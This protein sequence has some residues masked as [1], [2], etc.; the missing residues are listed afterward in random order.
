MQTG[1]DIETPSP[2]SQD[3]E[4]TSQDDALTRTQS[5]DKQVSLFQECLIVA[6]I[7]LAMFITQNALGQTVALV[8]IIAEHYNIQNP[9]VMSWF[10]AGY[11]LTV[12]TFILFSGRVGDL[13][14]W[15]RMLVIGY[16]WFGI[17]SI[18]SGLAWY[19]NHILFIFSRVMAG[20]GPAIALPNGLAMLGALYKPGKKKNMAFAIFGG[21]APG[22]AVSGFL[23]AGLF[24]LVW[25]PWAFWFI[26]L[27]LFATAA[28]AH[29][30]IP[31]PQDHKPGIQG[32]GISAFVAELDILG[33]TTGI[34][35]LILFN[36]AWNQAPI[37][38][39][40]DPGVIVTLILGALLMPAFFYIEVK[41]SKHPLLPFEVF[42]PDN[43]AVLACVAC[44]WSCFGI[45]YFYSW[46]IIYNIRGVS[47]LLGAAYFSPLIIVGFIAAITTGLLLARLRSAWVMLIAMCAFLTGT[48]L[49]VTLPPHQ[50]YWAQIFV[51]TVITPFGMD[52]SFPAAT[53]IV[54]DSVDKA[55]QGTAASLVN[56][57]VNYSISLGLGF[58]GTVEMYTHHSGRTEEEVLLH[59]YRSAIYMGLGLASLGV[60]LA[61]TFVLKSYWQERRDGQANEKI[62][63][64]D[65]QQ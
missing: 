19:S 49:L 54:S 4:K 52:M 27:V 43:A 16:I 35:A 1:E 10:I 15:K 65:E 5:L 8:Y 23:V 38:G 55:H 61:M 31:D 11:S 14:G 36:F 48:I 39:W 13:F 34:T 58:A 41:V 28:V 60:L 18:V 51:M 53:L 59:T 20:I 63:R 3:L 32:N 56:T 17:W 7:S 44:G 45:Y 21:C 46:Q 33:A 25:W 57:I 2:R 62:D 24:N 22:G 6:L 40:Q 30:A 29:F 9:G 42:T 47:V 50:I 26:G 12:G 37:V 64:V